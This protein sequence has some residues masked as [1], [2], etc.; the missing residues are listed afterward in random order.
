MYSLDLLFQ[1]IVLLC[2]L[3]GFAAGLFRIKLSSIG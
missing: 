2:G 3:L 1:F